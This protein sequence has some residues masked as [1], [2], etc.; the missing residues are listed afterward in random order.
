MAVVALISVFI[1]FYP[2][3]YLKTFYPVPGLPLLVHLHGLLFTAWI[4]LLV[5]QTSFV[6]VKR[7]DLHRRFGVAGTVLAALMT[8][9]GAATAVTALKSGRVSPTFFVVP[10]ASLVVFPVLV[11]AALLMRRRTDTHK[12]LMLIATGELLNAPIGRWPVIWRSTAFVAYGVNDIVAVL[13]LVVYDLATRRRLHPATLWGAMFLI[14]SQILR[15]V[16]GNTNLW[17]VFANWIKTVN[18]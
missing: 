3:Y 18:Y 17:L 1:G 7:T 12:R 16:V 11:A 4:V 14:V 10:A 5:V 9:V 13:P 2:T 6:A 15:T 8:V